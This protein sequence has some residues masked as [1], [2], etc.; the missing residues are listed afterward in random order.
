MIKK[1]SAKPASQAQKDARERNW[2]KAIIKSIKSNADRMYRAKTTHETEKADL[3]IIIDAAC[4]IIQ[5]WNK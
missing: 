2:N 3:G 5:N 4:N 1:N